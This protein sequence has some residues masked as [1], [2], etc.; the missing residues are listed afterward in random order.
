MTS[1]YD[2][3]V[4]TKTTKQLLESYRGEVLFDCQHCCWMRRLNAQ[5]QGSRTYERY[6][7]RGF[8]I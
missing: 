8:E 3:S 7:D 5:Y 2:F 6:Q 1:I 4:W